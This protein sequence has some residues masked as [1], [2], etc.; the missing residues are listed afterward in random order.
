MGFAQ[1]SILGGLAG[2]GYKAWQGDSWENVGK[3]A[4]VG[5]ALGGVGGHFGAKAMRSA[6]KSIGGL[7]SKFSIAN[8]GMKLSNR[9]VKVAQ[10]GSRLGAKGYYGSRA[11][12]YLGGGSLFRASNAVG[13]A[14]VATSRFIGNNVAKVNKYGGYA[15]GAMGAAAAL[16]IGSSVLGSNNNRTGHRI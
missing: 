5:A 8:M 16:K 2:G 3:G 15:M 1:R 4:A 9:A 7:A 10:A 13:M 6:G 12:G 14:A 11:G